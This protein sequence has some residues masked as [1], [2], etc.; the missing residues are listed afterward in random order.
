MKFGKM[1]VLE[2]GGKTIAQ[3]AAITRYLAR[4]YNLAGKTEFEEAEGDMIV[5]CIADS[6]NGRSCASYA[7]HFVYYNKE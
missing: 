6:M 2:V 4:K 1:P 7:N 5:D 3:S